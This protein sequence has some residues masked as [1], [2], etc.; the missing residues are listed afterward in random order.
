MRL[1]CLLV[2]S[3]PAAAHVV[4][5][6]TGEAKLNGSRLDYELRM[7][8]YEVA[9]IPNPE[10]QIF[11]NIHFRGAGSEARLIRH[12]CREDTGNLV[13]TGMYLFERD[14][15]E[16][17]VEC[18]FASITVPNHVHLL[19]AAR[20]DK[21]E[22][23]A[24][25]ISFTTAPVRFRPPTVLETFGRDVSAGFWRAAAG[26]AQVLFLAALVLAG[27]SRRELVQLAA[28][29][30]AGQAITAVAHLSTRLLLSPRFIEA[31]TA[32]TIAYL[33]FEILALPKAGQ[34][35]LVVGVLGLLHGMYF[36]ML[37][38]AGDYALGPFLAGAFAAQAAIIGA[39]AALAWLA[40]RV[41]IARGV[42][43]Q[44]A[45]ASLLLLTGVS[46]FLIRLKS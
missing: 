41:R 36:D 22:Q 30:L 9:H 29:F 16:F 40:S 12:S 24:F 8:L 19:R 37:L 26:M 3:M 35:W 17:D 14:V 6:S 20:G 43:L 25:D 38:A 23:A 42:L 7:P 4:S 2:L 44:R 10:K 27:R 5:M 28:M 33:A 15:Q 1:A 45:L 39:L 34:R 46:W 32:L 18:T 31:A 21:S 11:E 13:C